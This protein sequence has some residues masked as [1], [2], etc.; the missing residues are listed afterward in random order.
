MMAS[1]LSTSTPAQPIIAEHPSSNLLYWIGVLMAVVGIGIGLYLSYVRLADKEAV[2]IASD[3]FDC[4]SVQSSAYSKLAGIPIAYLGLGAYATIFALLM[5]E[6]RVSLVGEYGQMAL[7]GI[8]LFGV[9]YSAYLTYIEAFVLEKWCLW[10]VA[11]AMLMVGLFTLSLTRVVNA[12]GEDIE[13]E[14][15]VNE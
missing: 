14:N 4:A 1:T 11:S 10:C 9:V 3:T 13:L 5:L 6:T 7:F 12:L 2:C 15:E 8:T